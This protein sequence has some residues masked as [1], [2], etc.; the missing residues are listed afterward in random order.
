MAAETAPGDETRG[1][2]LGRPELLRTGLAHGHMDG[3]VCPFGKVPER[4]RDALGPSPVSWPQKH[5]RLLVSCHPTW[6]LPGDTRSRAAT[7]LWKPHDCGSTLP[8]DW[9]SVVGEA[10]L[11]SP[12]PG[13]NFVLASPSLM[14][15][16]GSF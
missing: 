3:T 6:Q 10:R 14:R 13:P 5:H 2:S 11:G 12:H 8:P 7:T 15:L 1:A 4:E 9:P 16:T